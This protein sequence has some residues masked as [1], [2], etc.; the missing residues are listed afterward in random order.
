MVSTTA[1]A[2]IKEW[3]KTNKFICHVKLNYKKVLRKCREISLIGGK[4][5]EYQTLC[6]NYACAKLTGA[7]EGW[8]TL[9][10]NPLRPI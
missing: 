1:V 10:I 3:R 8:L 9:K 5:K 4:Y 6:E 2:A 7:T